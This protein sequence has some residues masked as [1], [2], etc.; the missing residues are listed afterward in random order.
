MY[1]KT[2]KDYQISK[3]A[4]PIKTLIGIGVYI[5]ALV[6]VLPPIS[7]A[8]ATAGVGGE[9]KTPPKTDICSL[10][11]VVCEGFTIEE[12]RVDNHLP[13]SA[14]TTNPVNIIRYL[15]ERE[16]VDPDKLLRLA[17]CESQY[18]TTAVGD[19]GN[20]HGLFQIHRGYHPNISIEQAQDPW[21]STEWTINEIKEGRS[22]KW[23]CNNLL[24]IF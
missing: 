19:N 15:A 5:L 20:S 21:F 17:W 3:P 16:G 18:D 2:W 22:W 14:D 7:N 13:V 12:K 8:I 4:Y 10:N 11:D 23:T 1:Q 24:N 6:L 9:L